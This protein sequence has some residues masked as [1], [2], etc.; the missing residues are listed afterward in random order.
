MTDA[1]QAP[2]AFLWWSLDVECPECNR[3]NDLQ[4]SV[5]DSENT[6]AQHIF[7]NAWKKLEGWEVTCEHCDFK[8]QLAK[9]DY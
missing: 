3:S 4:Q 7:S 1:A 6:I 8:F 9:V 5:H 2:T